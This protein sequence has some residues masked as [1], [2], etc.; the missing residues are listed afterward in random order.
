LNQ[1]A[2]AGPV[3]AKKSYRSSGERPGQILEDWAAV[4]RDGQMVEFY[5]R[6]QGF[7][8]ITHKSFEIQ[9]FWNLRFPMWVNRSA[10][11][12]LEIVN[13]KISESQ[14]CSLI[15]SFPNRF[16]HA[17]KPPQHQHIE[18]EIALITHHNPIGLAACTNQRG[19]REFDRLPQRLQ[20]F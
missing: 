10:Q 9:K 18:R 4:E 7:S 11:T 12:T 6:N 20:L 8:F 2:L 16:H 17:S 5:C 13:S 15:S 3:R 14:N 19:G 1:G